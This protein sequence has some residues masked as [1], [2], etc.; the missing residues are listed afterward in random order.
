MDHVSAAKLLI[1]CLDLTSLQDNDSSES[2]TQ[3][4]KLTDDP[5]CNPAAICVYPQFIGDVKANINKSIRIATVINFPKGEN[6]V[7]ILKRDIPTA[8]KLGADELDVVFPY[9]ALLDGEVE[10]VR[11]YLHVARDI[12]GSKILKVI[13]ESGELKSYGNI[14][15][16]SQLCIEAKADFIKTSTGKTPVSATVEAANIILEAIKASGKKIG[17]KASGGI[18]TFSDAQSY[19]IL[20]QSIMG[21][22]W[23][24]P[25]HFRI[26][27]SSLLKDLLKTI[28][29]GY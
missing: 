22:D 4:C 28:A 10:S 14:S 9:K 6:D 8:I 15:L 12:C 26:G 20:A 1:S 18:K 7:D 16:A 17:F 29:Q 19:L 23:V 25:K 2:I 24:S 27:A 11:N 5:L 3:F 13:I 21:T